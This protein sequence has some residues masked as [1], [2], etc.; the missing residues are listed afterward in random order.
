MLRLKIPPRICDNLQAKAPKLEEIGIVMWRSQEYVLKAKLFR[1]VGPHRGAVFLFSKSDG[2]VRCGLFVGGIVRCCAVRFSH[3]QNH[4]VRCGAVRC[5]FFSLRC[6][7]IIRPTVV[8][9]G[10]VGRAPQ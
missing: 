9:Y 1:G 8:S 4:T 10:A 2:A 7:A 3:F 5:V 6:G